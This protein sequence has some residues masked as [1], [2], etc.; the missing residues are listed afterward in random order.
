MAPALA[1]AAECASI[2]ADRGSSGHISKL[3]TEARKSLR[4]CAAGQT[5][6]T[7]RF[8]FRDM[9]KPAPLLVAIYILYRMGLPV[10]RVKSLQRMWAQPNPFMGFGEGATE[11]FLLGHAAKGSFLHYPTK[12][13]CQDELTRCCWRILALAPRTCDAAELLGYVMLLLYLR[14]VAFG[15]WAVKFLRQQWTPLAQLPV[16][17]WRRTQERKKRLAFLP[18]RYVSVRNV[19]G[20]KKRRAGK[21]RIQANTDVNRASLKTIQTFSRPSSWT[22]H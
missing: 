20:R 6:D 16:E 8:L 18:Q 12:D 14:S 7:A 2:L 1:S 11:P 13:L 22:A 10:Q 9:E 19:R 21:V 4:G 5:A 3:A 15:R 17:F